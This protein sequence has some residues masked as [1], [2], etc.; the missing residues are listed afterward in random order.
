[1]VLSSNPKAYNLD[2]ML[3][4]LSHERSV[5]LVYLI[6]VKPGALVNTV[7]VSIFQRRLLKAT[8]LLKHGSGRNSRGVTQFEGRA[9]NELITH[10]EQDI[11]ESEAIAF[12]EKVIGL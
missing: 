3:E 9:L 8:I 5:F 10:P 12:L 6:G 2:K 11:D 7:L 1:M 4:Y